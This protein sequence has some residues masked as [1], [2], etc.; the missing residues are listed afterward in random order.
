V[1]KTTTNTGAPGAATA[2]REPEIPRIDIPAMRPDLPVIVKQ[3][4]KISQLPPVIKGAWIIDKLSFTKY[5][6]GP[7]RLPHLVWAAPF[8]GH[9]DAWTPDEMFYISN[10][11]GGFAGFRQGKEEWAYK[12][13]PGEWTF[14]GVTS[15]GRAW[16][17]EGSASWQRTSPGVYCFNSHGEGGY[18]TGVKETPRNGGDFDDNDRLYLTGMKK[19]PRDVI[20]R[21]EGK[22]PI[23]NI[24]YP[25]LLDG[26]RTWEKQDESGRLYLC[27]DRGTVYCFSPKGIIYW[28]FAAGI[29]VPPE[30]L[31]SLDDLIF[32]AGDRLFCLRDGA[33]RWT[34]PLKSCT[35]VLVD[36]DGTIFLSYVE[37]S[38]NYDY[39]PPQRLDREL[40]A[41]VD[42]DGRVLWRVYIH[43]FGASFLDPAG[44]LYV[45]G[46]GSLLCLSA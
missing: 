4:V 41:A 16:L 31:F 17:T 3:P 33:L 11:Y 28:Q 27:T 13:E 12:I 22:G 46:E 1:S 21:P 10:G 38:M 2:A 9:P 40:M 35:S 36:K 7:A 43:G 20:M 45:T 32:P 37:K 14:W 44:R 15:D 42:R 29:P 18:F 19:I 6:S 8:V 23:K 24:H 39:V 5:V 26:N 30:P 25:A 34:I